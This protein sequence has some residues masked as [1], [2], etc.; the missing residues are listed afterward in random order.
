MIKVSVILPVYGV[1]QYIEQCT[2][3][4]L[5]QTLEEMEF[6]FVDD[7]GPDDSIEVVHRTIIDHPRK[8][9]FRFLDPG[10]NIGAGMARNFAIPYAGGEYVAFVDSD[11]WVEPDMFATLYQHAK[12]CG[13]VDICYAQA[14]KDYS[15]G[16]PSKVLKNPSVTSGSFTH[17]KRA[18]FLVNYVSYFWTYIYKKEHLLGDT[19]RFP[20][21]HWSED[22]YFI[23]CSL[24]TA[25][26]V[27]RVD[28]PLYHY[29]V[30]PG[31]T[32]TTKDS[33]KYLQ[34]IAVFNKL[35]Q[36]AKSHQVFDEFKE[37]ID[38][39]YIKKCGLA[40]MIDYVKDSSNPQ[41]STFQDICKT[42]SSQVADYK[43]NKYFRKSLSVRLLLWM[44]QHIPSVFIK[45]VRLLF[46]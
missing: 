36:Y 37:E 33:T 27:A 38:F 29:Q 31:S 20:D 32:T 35:I 34:R 18:F 17:D 14:F 25:K 24:L 40:S 9:Q 39:I 12:A 46:I 22:S 41:S 23:S 26:S 45:V 21:S 4:L 5:A 19:L 44:S 42:V 15:S 13:D 43:L 7:H 8:S 11:D 6:I 1:A 28:Q 3:S 2:K 30:R 16:R 10:R